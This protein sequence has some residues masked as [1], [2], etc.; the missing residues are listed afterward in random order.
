MVFRIKNV[1]V[2]KEEKWEWYAADVKWGKILF[3]LS[4]LPSF[5]ALD[6]LGKI[7][8]KKTF[9]QKWWLL[10]CS[11]WACR[12]G[13][14]ATYWVVYVWENRPLSTFL[15]FEIINVQTSGSFC[16]VPYPKAVWDH[17]GSIRR[18]DLVLVRYHTDAW[19]H[20]PYF[21][22]HRNACTPSHSKYASIS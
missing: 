14:P 11:P 21:L 2:R 8:Q 15:Y 3:P 10:S 17:V 5:A 4:H 12:S 19:Q 22:I 20:I 13:L 1:G 18:Y 7:I 6:P 9:Y 16:L